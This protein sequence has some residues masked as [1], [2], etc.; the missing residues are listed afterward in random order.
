MTYRRSVLTALL[1]SVLLSACS[2]GGSERQSE[3]E[4]KR[5]AEKARRPAAELYWQ[6]YNSIGSAASRSGGSG[7]FADCEEVKEDSVTYR[8]TT[9]LDPKSKSESLE[10]LTT[11][12]AN[13]LKSAG[14][15]LSPASG[16]HRSATKNG[17]SVELKPSPVS[18]TSVQLQVR[19]ECVNVGKAADVLT[20]DYA[21]ASDN[22]NSSQASASPVPT[23]FVKP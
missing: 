23:N 11:A 6:L 22:Y 15:I 18:G 16:L 20:A 19:S 5:T 21:N 13:R 7:Y 3:A 14:W 10:T 1:L 4:G 9:L 2:N 12:V 17:I 8:V